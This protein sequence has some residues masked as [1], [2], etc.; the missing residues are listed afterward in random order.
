MPGAS[1]PDVRMPMLLIPAILSF[2]KNKTVQRYENI[3]KMFKKYGRP[4]KDCRP[5]FPREPLF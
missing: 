1:P 2:V 3:S 4:K 5:Y